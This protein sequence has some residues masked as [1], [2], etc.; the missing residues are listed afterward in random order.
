M[1]YVVTGLEVSRPSVWGFMFIWLG[2][3]SLLMFAIVVE[4]WIFSFSSGP[5]FMLT[6]EFWIP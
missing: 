5:V 6:V 2:V 3:G 4:A 1:M